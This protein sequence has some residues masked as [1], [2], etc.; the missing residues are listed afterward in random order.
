MDLHVVTHVERAVKRPIDTRSR[1][2]RH[3]FPNEPNA[4]PE[5]GR[6]GSLIPAAVELFR[7]AWM[8]RETPNEEEHQ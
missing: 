7:A 5:T 6:F 1:E 3:Q 4:P 2:P 8:Q